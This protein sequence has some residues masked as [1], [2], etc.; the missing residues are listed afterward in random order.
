MM[1]WFTFLCTRNFKTGTGEVLFECLQRAVPYR[2]IDNW[3]E[4]WLDLVVME[5]ALILLWVEA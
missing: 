1:V 2:E 5:L 4:S 3:Q